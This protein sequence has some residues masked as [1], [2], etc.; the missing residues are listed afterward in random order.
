M[1]SISGTVW[2]DTNANAIFDPGEV[3][4]SVAVALFQ[5][6]VQTDT[7]TSDASG[8]FTFAENPTGNDEVAV[9]TPGFSNSTPTDVNGMTAVVGGVA[10]VGLVPR[11]DWTGAAGDGVWG[12]PGN[13]LNGVVATPTS[14]VYLTSTSGNCTIPPGMTLAGLHLSAGYSG[15]VTLAGDLSVGNL[16]LA[17]AGGI[18]DQPAPGST[19]TVTQSLNWTAGTL[20]STANLANVV[21][22]GA[23]ATIAPAGAGTVNCG[24][25]VSLMGGA[26][27]T[28]SPG[29]VHFTNPGTLAVGQN[30][31]ANVVTFYNPDKVKFSGNIQQV[32]VTN[33]RLGVSGPGTW[34]AG[35]GLYN[36]GG[37]VFLN[38]SV[39]VQ[40]Q[41]IIQANGPRVASYYQDGTATL[42]IGSGSTLAVVNP[43]MVASGTLETLYNANLADTLTDQSGTIQGDLQVLGGTVQICVNLDPMGAKHYGRLYATGAVTMRGGTYI[44]VIDGTTAGRSDRW[45][46]GGNFSVDPNMGDTA[47]LSPSDPAAGATVA[48]S[49]WKIIRSNTGTYSGTFATTNLQYTGGPL[50]RSF[51][52]N[53][54]GTP[55]VEVNLTT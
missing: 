43:A 22:N 8:N 28:F 36:S 15:T 46:S 35:C 4:A 21:L 32:D 29:E 34:D 45:V 11:A 48:N 52:L 40:L 51:T 19:L 39:T 12:N 10:N 30:C 33:A 2:Y 9:T 1:P 7:T 53:I 38:S 50:A 41:G 49:V 44:P 5:N 23:T 55:P 16:E 25:N 24:S 26:N 37:S 27:A 18:L 20:N 47:T 31:A 14:A 17:A 3:G 42:A 6:G 13:W 54:G